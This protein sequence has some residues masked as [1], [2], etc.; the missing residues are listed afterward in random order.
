MTD[1]QDGFAVVTPGSNCGRTPALSSW[2]A[3]SLSSAH[4]G[5]VTWG[6]LRDPSEPP[7]SSPASQGGRLGEMVGMRHVAYAQHTGGAPSHLGRVTQQG[8]PKL[9]EAC[10][11]WIRG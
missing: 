8:G 6:E 7:C 2:V 1:A 4:P 9:T 11:G 3:S 5:Y 10:S